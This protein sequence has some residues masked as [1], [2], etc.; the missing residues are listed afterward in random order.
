MKS[1]DGGGTEGFKVA[2]DLGRAIELAEN[3]EEARLKLAF[4]FFSR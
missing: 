4:S 1:G 2:K 3:E